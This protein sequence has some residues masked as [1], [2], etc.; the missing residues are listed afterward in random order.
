MIRIYF[1]IIAILCPLLVN[2]QTPEHN[3]QV[4]LT[5]IAATRYVTP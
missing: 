5:R 3:L 2:A 1:I 4:V